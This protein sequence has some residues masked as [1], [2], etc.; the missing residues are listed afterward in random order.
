M[1]TY[2][3]K[4]WRLNKW[5]LQYANSSTNI[6]FLRKPF[7][8]HVIH[9]PENNHVNKLD[10]RKLKL[11]FQKKKESEIIKS[12]HIVEKTKNTVNCPTL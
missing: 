10:Q 3:L 7:F 11:C 2:F 12:D 1:I 5:F 4:I 9:T 8:M 6:F